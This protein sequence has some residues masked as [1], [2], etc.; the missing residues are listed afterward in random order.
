M[1]SIGLVMSNFTL[2][3]ADRATHLRIIVISIVA[4]FLVIGVGIGAKPPGTSALQFDDNAI[5][6]RPAKP[7]SVTS[8]E[9]AAIR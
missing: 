3:R 9:T 7:I 6:N 4:A 8:R 5:A 2:L 1:L